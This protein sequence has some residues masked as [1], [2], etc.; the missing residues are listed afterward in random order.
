MIREVSRV[1]RRGTVV[2]PAS[3]RKRF[4]LQDGSMVM[5]EERDEGILLRPAAVVPVETYSPERKAQFL[6]SNAVD[7]ADYRAA[8]KEVRAMGL[9]PK[10]IRHRPPSRK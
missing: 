7:E 1:G 2:I 8:V 5:A 3:L 9:D 4:R 10:N 6:L